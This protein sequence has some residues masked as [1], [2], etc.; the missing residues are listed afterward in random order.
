MLVSNS[1]LAFNVHYCGDEIASISL[2]MAKKSL[3]LETNC[4]GIVEEESN[5]CND[6]LFQ[7]QETSDKFQENITKIEFNA[8][9]VETQNKF[10]E[11]FK[12]SNFKASKASIFYPFLDNLPPIFKRNCQFIFYA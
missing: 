12:K 6:K 2:K 4:C 3:D 9:V 11:F 7:I 5:C 10:V 8:I 1:G